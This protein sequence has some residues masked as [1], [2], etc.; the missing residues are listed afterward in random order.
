[1][2]DQSQPPSNRSQLQAIILAMMALALM[3]AG[4]GVSH[5][6]DALESG[7]S[8]RLVLGSGMIVCAVSVVGVGLW[9]LFRSR[10]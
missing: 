8:L 2:N 7:R 3:L 5:V 1:M 9:A 4:L 10:R 6:A